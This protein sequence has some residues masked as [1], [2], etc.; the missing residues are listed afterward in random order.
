MAFTINEDGSKRETKNTNR[1]HVNAHNSVAWSPPN[2]KQHQKNAEEGK[3]GKNFKKINDARKKRET[4]LNN[5]L[6][7]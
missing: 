6:N 2:R 1:G 7:Q 5:L 3:Y 4:E